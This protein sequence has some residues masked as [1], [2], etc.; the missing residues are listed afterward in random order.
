MATTLPKLIQDALI[1]HKNSHGIITINYL[2]LAGSLLQLK[3]TAQNFDVRKRNV[4]HRTDNLD[5][6]FLQRRGFTS[7]TTCP[8]H[9]LRLFDIH[10]R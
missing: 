3:A 7:T 1:T 10:Q 5:A 2:E 4:L 8:A 6:L 9:L